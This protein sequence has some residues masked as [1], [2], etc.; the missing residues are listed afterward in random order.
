VLDTVIHVTTD[1]SLDRL[2]NGYVAQA[3]RLLHQAERCI[4]TVGYNKIRPQCDARTAAAMSGQMDPFLAI[5]LVV[6]AIDEQLAAYEH[7]PM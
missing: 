1:R 7:R 3:R 4:P 6:S 2:T 5:K